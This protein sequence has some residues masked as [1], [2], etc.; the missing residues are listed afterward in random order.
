MRRTYTITEPVHARSSII[1]SAPNAG[2]TSATPLVIEAVVLEY[3][4]QPPAFPLSADENAL[5]DTLHEGFAPSHVR[6][7][8]M[9]GGSAVGAMPSIVQIG[10]WVMSMPSSRLVYLP[11]GDIPVASKDVVVYFQAPGRTDT[12]DIEFTVGFRHAE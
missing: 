11:T 7:R 12:D 2:I 3:I 4:S 1:L 6:M 9:V 8:A 5:I 10:D